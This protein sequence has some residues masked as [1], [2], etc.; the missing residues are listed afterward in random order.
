MENPLVSICV[1]TRN[2]AAALAQTLADI[3]RQTYSPLDI[4]ISDNASED[5]TEALCRELLSTDPRIRYVRHPRNI[6]LHRNHN[7]CLDEARGPYLCIVHDHD[8]RDPGIV[9]EYV[10]FLEEH[11]GVGVVC[12]DWDLIDDADRRIGVRQHRVADVTAGLDYIGQTIR[13]GRSSIGIP[14]AMIRK[15]ALGGA[16]F[17]E[18]APIGFGDFP[19]WFTLAEKS[20][21]GHIG[22]RLWSWRQNSESHS[23]RTIE[24]IARD[25]EF[26]LEQYCRDH[27][28]RWPEHRDL[29]AVWR[30]NIRRYLFWALAYEVTLHFRAGAPRSADASRSLFEIMDYRL[31]PQQFEYAMGQLKS[32][33][34][35]PT[36]HLFVA[37]LETIIRLRLTAPLGWAA[38]HQAGLRKLLN[39]E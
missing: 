9:G 29:V 17:V 39:L 22:R 26:N 4:L 21:V 14:G 31:T 38:R 28:G 5:G 13:S 33:R 30:A 37:V 25:Y 34:K 1:P 19:V 12:S 23:A 20:D 3:R 24:S 10:T 15:S 36:E 8:R 11:S 7:F 18:G 6:G 35:G 16:R 27:L 32:Y 2:R